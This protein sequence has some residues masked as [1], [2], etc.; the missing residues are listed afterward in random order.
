[1]LLH[2]MLT[3]LPLYIFLITLW[4]RYYLNS[5]SSDYMRLKDVKVTQL[6]NKTIWKGA[7]KIW[8]CCHNSVHRLEGSSWPLSYKT[9]KQYKDSNNSLF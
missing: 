6:N 5:P 4:S 1:M 7:Q 9:Q 3:I 8:L 2:A